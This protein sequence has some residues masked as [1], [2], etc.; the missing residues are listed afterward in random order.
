MILAA[1]PRAD[2]LGDLGD[3]FVGDVEAIGLVEPA[4]MID[5]DQQEAA[6]AA[7]V[8]RLVERGAEHL[9]QAGA[10]EFAGQRIEL[11]KLLE[12]ALAFVALVDD[13]HDAMRPQR[14]AVGAGEPAA[15][16]LQPDFLRRRA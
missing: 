14:L 15:G 4:E 9:D 6:G 2:A 11:R 7:E 13:A 1:Q 5:G 8:H 12:L 16:V 10:V 3:H